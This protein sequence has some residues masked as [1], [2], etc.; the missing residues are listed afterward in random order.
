MKKLIYSVARRYAKPLSWMINHS[1]YRTGLIDPYR[2]S[3]QWILGQMGVRLT[4]TVKLPSGEALSVFVGDNVSEK[5]A[6]DGIYEPEIASLLEYF[7]KPGMTFFDVGAHVGIFSLLAA[8][9]VGASGRVHSFEADPWTYSLLCHNIEANGL[10]QVTTNNLA[11]SYM[12]G[13]ISLNFAPVDNVGSNSIAPVGGG[14]GFVKVDAT[15]LDAYLERNSISGV[16]F[17]KADIEGAEHLMLKGGE[18]LFAQPNRPSLVLEVN[19]YQ[20]S[21][22][23]ISPHDIYQAL[24]Q[25]GYFIYKI[26][27][28]YTETYRYN[29]VHERVYNVFATNQALD[30]QGRLAVHRLLE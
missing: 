3:V 12:E 30:D 21:K 11:V 27:R 22:L 24:N 9:L 13:R 8:R 19:E 15:S 10:S 16:D 4:K 25:F 1:L 29:Q 18:R 26:D 28:Q 5:I 14:G 2:P 17:I 23:G 20:L 7:L 6:S